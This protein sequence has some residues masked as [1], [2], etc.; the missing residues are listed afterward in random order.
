[1]VVLVV[2]VVMVVEVGKVRTILL[3]LANTEDVLFALFD[4]VLY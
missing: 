1:M 4:Y 3:Q 2:V